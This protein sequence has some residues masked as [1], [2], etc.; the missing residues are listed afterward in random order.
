MTSRETFDQVDDGSH[1]GGYVLDQIP[2]P[3]MA[4]V[5]QRLAN[6]DR[7]VIA[8]LGAGYSWQG[9]DNPVPTVTVRALVARHW[10]V[11]PDLDLF[12]DRL[13]GCMTARGQLA[14]ARFSS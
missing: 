5:L 6:G 4:K 3:A 14:L 9:S 2:T 7:I 10:I 8:R 13:S 11:P 12:S 1:L